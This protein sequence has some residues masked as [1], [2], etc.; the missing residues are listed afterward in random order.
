VAFEAGQMERDRSSGYVCD[1]NSAASTSTRR[2]PDSASALTG[3]HPINRFS[4]LALSISMH[5]YEIRPRKDRAR[6]L[7]S[8]LIAES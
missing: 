2:D 5:V 7:E 3:L 1:A 4:P 6:H 8:F